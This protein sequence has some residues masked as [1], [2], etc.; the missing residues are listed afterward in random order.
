MTANSQHGL[1]TDQPDRSATAG[2][3]QG[4]IP[5]KVGLASS[6]MTWTMRQTVLSARVMIHTWEEW[7]MHQMDVLPFRGASA[8]W[9][10]GVTGISWRPTK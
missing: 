8:H 6:S 7:L 2:I 1:N 5:G 3:L 9:R 4:L 10:D